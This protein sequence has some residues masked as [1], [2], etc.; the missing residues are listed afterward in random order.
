MFK[1]TRQQL[2]SF[3]VF[4]SLLIIF[5]FFTI[6][7]RRPLVSILKLPFNIVKFIQREA[8]GL[9]FYHRNLVRNEILERE[10]EILRQKVNSLNEAYLENA[11]LKDSLDYKRKSSLK[12]IPARVIARSAD[13]WS[14]SL[15]LDKGSESGIK[16]GMG[17]ITYLGLAGRVMEVKDSTSYVMLLSDPGLGVSSLVQRSRQEGLVTG[18]LGNNLIMKY[19][20]EDADIQIGDTIV[21]SGLNSL[22]PKG[23]LIGKVIEIGNEFSGLSRYAIVKPAVNFSNIEE[24]LVVV[25]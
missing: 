16:Q 5:F 10:V 1:P 13:N 2:K 11:R 23:V 24:I 14:A 8:G 3:S 9:I 18:T 21:S 17:V 15:I 20:P 6:P 7:L 22:Y 12:L 25:P 4:I 19:L